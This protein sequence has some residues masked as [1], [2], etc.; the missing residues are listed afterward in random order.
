MRFDPAPSHHRIRY[1]DSSKTPQFAGFFVFAACRK[2]R[3]P[4]RIPRPESLLWHVCGKFIITKRLANCALGLVA[5]PSAST[6]N[7]SVSINASRGAS[8]S[9]GQTSAPTSTASC[10]LAGAQ[11][12]MAK[13]TRQRAETSAIKSPSA[14]RGASARARPSV[15]SWRRCHARSRPAAAP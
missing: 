2:G 9:S 11:R 7:T 10:C 15:A 1:R 3:R 14:I 5:T 13:A 4:R 8:R 6:A 12:C